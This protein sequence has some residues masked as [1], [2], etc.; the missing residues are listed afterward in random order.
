MAAKR[1]ALAGHDGTHF[2][3]LNLPAASCRSEIADRL[4]RVKAGAAALRAAARPPLEPSFGIGSEL[5]ACLVV[6]HFLGDVRLESASAPKGT[7]IPAA[8]TI[9][10][11][12][13]TP[14]CNGPVM[15]SLPE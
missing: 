2:P 3:P 14:F 12:E 11:Y 5:V 6:G 7:F 8:I 1:A 9:A 4:G 10:I 15:S 13:Y